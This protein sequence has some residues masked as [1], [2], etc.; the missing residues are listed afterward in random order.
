MS[1]SN[2]DVLHQLTQL[3]IRPPDPVWLTYSRDTHTQRVTG[4]NVVAQTGSQLEDLRC[5]YDPAG[6]IVRQ[7]ETRGAPGAAVRTQCFGQ[8]SLRQLVAAWTAVDDCA[9]APGAASNVLGGA[10]PY[11]SSWAYDAAGSRTKQIRHQI[12]GGLPVDETTTYSMGVDG[13][14]HALGQVSVEGGQSTSY[15]YDAVGQTVS[16]TDPAG[17]RAF[18]WTAGHR[19]ETITTPT[20][21]TLYR[22]DADGSELVRRDP[23]ASTLYLPGGNEISIASGT[24]TVAVGRRS[25]THA[26]VTIGVRVGSAKPTLTFADLQNT[27]QVSLDWAGSTLTRRAYDPYGVPLDATPTPWPN[28]RGYLNQ[29]TG[30][31]N[32]VD[33]GARLY[34]PTVGRFLTPDPILDTTNPI[35]PNG[36]T[37]ADNT[38]I[39]KSDPTGQRPD[40]YTP[41]MWRAETNARRTHHTWGQAI[42][43]AY[44]P[45][46][47]LAGG[48]SWRTRQGMSSGLLGPREVTHEDA[49]VNYRAALHWTHPR[50][51]LVDEAREKYDQNVETGAYVVG[52]LAL[53]AAVVAFPYTSIAVG[54]ELTE[55]MLAFASGGSVTGGLGFLT[56]QFLTKTKPPVS[57][58]KSAG[59]VADDWPVISGIVRDAAKGKGNFGIGSG[60]A[61]QAET[62]GRS[63]VGDGARL[64][65]DGKTWLSQDGLR[66][67]RPPSY[68]PRLDKWQ[69]S[70]ESR[71]E[72]SGQW[73][74]NGHLDILDMP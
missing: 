66:Q 49:E 71:W 29:P 6:N 16:Q 72:P 52:A 30:D 64:A 46:S 4:V 62:A 35:S 73:Q 65:S 9:T 31:T 59:A 58:A 70:F 8:D 63:W 74:T 32:L 26:G 41:E 7:V 11:W 55:G 48:Y 37:Y 2:F 15:S 17:V 51:G 24:D 5:S 50:K 28:T 34:N 12:P 43:T 36:Y 3:T 67:W 13:H 42:E 21:T 60:T 19:P 40:D 23:S 56:C 45:P 39:T 68:K 57:A 53:I 14:A 33:T 47:G 54:I 25:Y 27:A 20:G 38:P 69:S 18:T 22:Y 1:A 44:D 61:A 10:Q